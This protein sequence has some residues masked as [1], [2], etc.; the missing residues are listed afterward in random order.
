MFLVVRKYKTQGNK[1]E[2]SSIIDKGFVPLISKIKGFV[3]Y[4]CLF[5]DENTLISVGVF[6]DKKGADDSVKAAADFVIKNLLK[7]FPDKPEIS[8]GEVFTH[9]RDGLGE[10]RKT[11]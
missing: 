11:A 5:S 6:Q 9:G 4:Y 2:I 7:Y 1:Q 3:D 10:T 8:S